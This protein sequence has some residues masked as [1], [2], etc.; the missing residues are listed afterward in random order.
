MED[1]LLDKILTPNYQT[2]M[3]LEDDI[4][5]VI[6]ADEDHEGYLY[7]RRVCEDCGAS[8]PE[9]ILNI[10]E[11]M[12]L[13]GNSSPASDLIEYCD[14]VLIDEFGEDPHELTLTFM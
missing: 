1:T 11:K 10:E 7:I 13:L 12:Y 5:L 3:V 6:E 8:T 9:V 4:S 2:R 14:K